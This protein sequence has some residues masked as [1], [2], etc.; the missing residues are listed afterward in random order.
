MANFRVQL[1]GA[2]FSLW[3]EDPL[4]REGV[5]F[6]RIKLGCK[7][8]AVE[9]P[10]FLGFAVWWDEFCKRMMGLLLSS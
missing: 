8:G 6:Q 10:F 2:L 9:A 4:D 1:G 3:F 5:S 7:I